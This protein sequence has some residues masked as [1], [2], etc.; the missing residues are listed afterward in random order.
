MTYVFS[1]DASEAQLIVDA[2]EQLPYCKVKNLIA[3]VYEQ[4]RGQV[5]EAKKVEEKPATEQEA[6]P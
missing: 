4:V 6:K 5:S 3:N 2:L 1:F